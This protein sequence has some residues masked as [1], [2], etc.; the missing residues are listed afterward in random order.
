M[1]VHVTCQDV[2]LPSRSCV[3]AAIKHTRDIHDV[4]WHFCTNVRSCSGWQ[5]TLRPPFRKKLRKPSSTHFGEECATAAYCSSQDNGVF[6]SL[7]GFRHGVPSSLLPGFVARVGNEE[8]P[9]VQKTKEH[10]SCVDCRHM[11]FIVTDGILHLVLEP[12]PFLSH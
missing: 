6:T 11:H 1:W 5:H 2:A 12:R 9:N 4:D 10:P 7:K 3:T 8:F